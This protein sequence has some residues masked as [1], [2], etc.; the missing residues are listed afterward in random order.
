M[1]IFQQATLTVQRSINNVWTAVATPPVP[2]QLTNLSPRAVAE[3]GGSSPFNTYKLFSLGCIP[4]LLQGDQL[5]D[6]DATHNDPKTGQNTVYEV[7]GNPRVF[8][9]HL[10][11]VLEKLV[12][13]I[14]A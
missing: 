10:E 9:N 1:P 2:A 5:V 4:N 11:V 3:M 12:G 6:T 7:M 14:P 8:Q 13:R